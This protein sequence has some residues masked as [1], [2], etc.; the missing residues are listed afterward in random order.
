MF[1]KKEQK[2][3]QNKKLMNPRIGGDAS[4][5]M[6][7]SGCSGQQIHELKCEGHCGL[8]KSLDEFSRAQRTRGSRW[9]KECGMA[10]KSIL[11]K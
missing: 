3:W 7:C 5:G 6:R 10:L 1:S 2:N 4:S 9:C 8:V 11:M